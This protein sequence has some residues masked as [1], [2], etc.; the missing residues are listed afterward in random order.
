[1]AK[2]IRHILLAKRTVTLLR[3][4]PDGLEVALAGRDF[5]EALDE[6]EARL[7]EQPSFF[8]GASAI[9]SLG[10]VMPSAEEMSRLRGLLAAAGIE[11]RAISGSDL[12]LEALARA[13]GLELESRSQQLSESARSLAADFAGARDD[14]AQRRKRGE[15]S[16]RRAKLEPEGARL[17]PELRLVEAPPSTLYHAATL[18]GGQ[19]LHHSGN[20]VVVGDVNPGAEL[21]ATGDILVFG[22]LA[23]IAHAGAQG[24]EGARI[25]AVDLAATQLR[26]S[27]YIAADEAPANDLQAPHVA[28][29]RDGQI[30]ILS[31]DGF[32]QS[33]SSRAS[34]A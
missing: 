28:V 3:G 8:R 27:T 32:K 6:L 26:I 10:D 9:A 21:I 1:M 4:R 31:L 33:E 20:I 15:A 29:A 5:G 19:T 23:G 11:L 12:G 22:R 30:A 16:V 2:G 14:I 13:Q 7:A 18:R 25:Y 34:T 17:A 24:D